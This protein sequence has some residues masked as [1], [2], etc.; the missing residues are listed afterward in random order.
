MYMYVISVLLDLLYTNRSCNGLVEKEYVCEQCNKRFATKTHLVF[1]MKI[2]LPDEDKP[3]KCQYCTRTFAY[4]HDCV[5]HMRLHLGKIQHFKDD[6]ALKIY[7]PYRGLFHRGK[8][9][10]FCKIKKSCR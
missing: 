2:H 5:H 8:F 10:S 1:H 3:F 9:Y 7:I 4:N 6:L